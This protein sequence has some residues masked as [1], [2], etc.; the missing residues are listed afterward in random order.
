MSMVTTTLTLRDL[1]EE[2]LNMLHADPSTRPRTVTL[3]AA[4]TDTTGTTVDLAAIDDAYVEPPCV[5]EIDQE[6]MLVTA[7]SGT[8]TYTVSRGY[9]GSTAAT[10]LINA[11]GAVNPLY[12]RHLV[13][14]QLQ[15]F[16]QT[17]GNAHLPQVTNT[18]LTTDGSAGV[19]LPANCMK[20]LRVL[21]QDANEQL[22]DLEGSWREFSWLS[23]SLETDQRRLQVPA[24]YRASGTVLYVT[25]QRYWSWSSEPPSETS[26][27]SFPTGGEDLPALYVSAYLATG[28]ELTRTMLDRIEDWPESRAENRQI[29]RAFIRDRWVQFWTRMEEARS[30]MDKPMTRHYRR[31]VKV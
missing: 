16:F 26:T 23:P 22:Y 15:R 4:L 30:T 8:P 11:V 7:K 21:Y 17:V 28:L 19:A 6:L 12:P 20:V 1:I 24:R 31:R 2:T 27:I 14:K 29:N 10:H 13:S 18:T 25:Y 3:A 9:A 5:L